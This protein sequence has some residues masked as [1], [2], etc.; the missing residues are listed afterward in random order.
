VKGGERD[1]C[2]TISQNFAGGAEANN[3]HPSRFAIFTPRIK[4]G[5]SRIRSGSVNHSF[6]F[7][8]CFMFF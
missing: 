7:Y 3:V 6:D 4:P 8:E 5:T 1:L 2:K